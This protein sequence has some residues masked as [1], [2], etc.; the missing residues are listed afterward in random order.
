MRA[1]LESSSLFLERSGKRLLSQ[2]I[3]GF[4]L[5]LSIAIPVAGSSTEADLAQWLA[6]SYVEIDD[7]AGFGEYTFEKLSEPSIYYTRGIVANSIL[8]GLPVDAPEKIVEWIASVQQPNG[9]FEDP[10][11]D[12]PAL[13]ET[14]W[15]IQTL[16]LL[17][18]DLERFPETLSFLQ[19]ALAAIDL[20]GT[21]ITPELTSAIWDA[22]A[23]IECYEEFSAAG[24]PMDRSSLEG[25][26]IALESM[27][28]W[29]D[30]E[31]EGLPVWDMADVQFK[32]LSAHTLALAQVAPESLT[33]AA[34]GFLEDQL[35]IV[36]M[37]PAHFVACTRIRELLIAGSKAF[38]WEEIP[39]EIE[40]RV[41]RYLESH[42]FPILSD[43]GGFG[44]T[45]SEGQIWVD[46]Q[47]TLPVVQI[48]HLLGRS[49]PLAEALSATMERLRIDPG[50]LYQIQVTRNPAL[51]YFAL[52]LAREADWPVFSEPKMIAYFESCIE[53]PDST[54]SDV[55]YAAKG[56]A[57]IAGVTPELMSHLTSRLDE[58]NAAWIQSRTDSV[59][60]LMYTFNLS[61]E[62]IGL[63]ALL[64]EYREQMLEALDHSMR[65]DVVWQLTMVDSLLGIESMPPAVVTD[66]I[67]SQRLANGGFRVSVDL[68]D[69]LMDVSDTLTTYKA[70]E[71]L[72]HYGM[73]SAVS[74]DALASFLEECRYEIGYLLA[75]E[76][77][78]VRIGDPL[79]VDFLSTYYGLRLR[80]FVETGS[81]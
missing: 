14:L 70:I 32:A 12:V 61:V 77:I 39:Q 68:P 64:D 55:L 48:C 44:W 58:G 40:A 75:P 36:E 7:S 79:D 76:D 31:I 50:W 1:A 4:L 65:V 60:A 10:T 45:G 57:D 67:L 46:P 15:A 24:F 2:I 81:L 47:M 21:E 63:I 53:S 52:H 38:A 16:R 56:W 34:R 25:F 26:Q 22:Y 72:M 29:M 17:G 35:L 27:T 43:K 78:L 59:V 19:N 74:H 49:Y 80:E 23:I 28:S 41:W 20:G 13:H 3:V 5:V 73:A 62:E 37:A 30:L 42:I 71:T 8:N 69:H 51:S 6:L 33:T 18:A 9:S 66:F 54:P 11:V